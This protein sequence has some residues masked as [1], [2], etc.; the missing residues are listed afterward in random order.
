M[1]AMPIKIQVEQR[2]SRHIGDASAPALTGGKK[3]MDNVWESDDKKVVYTLSSNG[4][5]IIGQRSAAGAATVSGTIT[6][7]GWLG[8]AGG[9]LGI[10]LDDTPVAA[11]ANAHL[12][13]G[14]Q[15]APLSGQTYNWG[16]TQGY[17]AAGNLTGGVAEADYGDVIQGSATADSIKGLGGN[18]ALGGGRRCSVKRYRKHYKNRS[19]SCYS[20]L[21]WRHKRHVKKHTLKPA[22]C[23]DLL[24][25]GAS[26]PV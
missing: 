9:L 2:G 7:Q 25:G 21:G 11:N 20:L 12:Y 1:E 23:T 13:N 10:N 26:W 6:V 19:C 22:Q 5:L 4:D 24:C 15:H 3:V 18:D 14:D 17:D 8:N 16:T